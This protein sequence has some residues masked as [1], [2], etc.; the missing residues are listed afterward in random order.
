MQHPPPPTQPTASQ[1]PRRLDK[2]GEALQDESMTTTSGLNTLAYA[3]RLTAAGVERQQAE[4][5]A[6][7]LNEAVS[8]G[9]ATK[10][11]IESVKEFVEARIERAVNRVILALVAVVGLGVAAIKWL[12]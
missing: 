3:R 5:H 11:D 12:P 4:A 7:A 9:I 8:Q 6:E 2:K 1:R 10:A